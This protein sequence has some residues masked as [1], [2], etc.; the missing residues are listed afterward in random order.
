MPPLPSEDYASF[1]SL[2][3]IE[4]LFAAVEAQAANP[5]HGIFGPDSISWKINRE[6]ALFLG[7]GRAAILQLAHPWV[8]TALAQH[9]SLLSRPIARFHNTFRIVFT[10]IF[11]TLDQALAAAR[12]LYALHRGICGALTENVAGWKQGSHYQANEIAA[13]RWVYA[14]LV[15]SAVMAYEAVLGPLSSQERDA[16]YSETKTLA[17]LFGLPAAALPADWAAFLLYIREMTASDSLGVGRTA[18]SM[19]QDLLSGAGSW[20]RPPRWYHALT[21][22]WLPERLRDEFALDFRDADRVAAERALRRVPGIYRGLPASIR[23][24]GPWREAQARIYQRRAGLVTSLSNR[25]WIGQP[26][27]PFGERM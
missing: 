4:A 1:V 5:E 25:F 11:G 16:Y 10:M 14:T 15:D 2:A 23:F 27:L 21:A 8:A 7:A 22:L 3:K 20:I 19:A 26:R 18:R 6:A 24:I 17:A 12:H 9:S 13:L